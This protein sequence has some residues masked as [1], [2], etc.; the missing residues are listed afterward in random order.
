MSMV[1]PSLSDIRSP[2]AVHASRL[3]LCTNCDAT[4]SSMVQPRSASA[5]GKGLP[6]YLR[7]SLTSTSLLKN[8][9]RRTLYRVRL[10][11]FLFNVS[12]YSKCLASWHLDVAT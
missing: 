10:L 6:R 9:R 11:G 7:M 12:A 2:Q 8:P 3:H 5:V 4:T 1:A